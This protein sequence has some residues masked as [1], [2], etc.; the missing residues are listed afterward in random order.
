LEIERQIATTLSPLTLNS[1][2]AREAPAEVGSECGK[3][4]FDPIGTRFRHASRVRLPALIEAE[5]ARRAV[6]AEFQLHPQTLRTGF[7]DG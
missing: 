5:Q 3:V 2:G 1:I 7:E 4:D 6:G